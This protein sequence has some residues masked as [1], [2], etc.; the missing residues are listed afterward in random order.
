MQS[1]PCSLWLYVLIML[2][3][4]TNPTSVS[5]TI[6]KPPLAKAQTALIENKIKYGKKRFSIRQMKFF[7]PAVWHVALGSWRRIHQAAAPCNVT[8]GSEMTYIEFARWQHC[9]MWHM[10]L[11]S[12]HWIHQVAAPCNVARGS[13]TTCQWICPNF[14]ILEFYYWFQFWPYHRSRHVI[15]H[16]SAKFYPNRIAF[17]RKK[18]RRVNFQDGGSPPSWILW[19]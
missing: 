9:A 17:S 10:A 15:L 1:T 4:R 8:H 16:Q 3:K 12:R 2:S 5:N 13:W 11:W 7:H 6:R 14:R 19:I 18:W